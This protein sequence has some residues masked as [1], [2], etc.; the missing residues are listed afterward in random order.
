MK[1][2]FEFG[3]VAFIG[4]FFIAITLNLLSIMISFN[5]AKIYAEQITDTIEHYNG[6]HQKSYEAI[7]KL[8]ACKNCS[9]EISKN[10]DKYEI[11]VKYPLS[12]TIIN[13]PVKAMVNATTKALDH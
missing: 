7:S 1:A 8:K 2:G 4:M 11:V 10:L 5:Q 12:F 3:I 6:Y 13:L 9:Y